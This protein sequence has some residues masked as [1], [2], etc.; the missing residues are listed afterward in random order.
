[1]AD[2]KRVAR[3][4]ARMR[5]D[6]LEEQVRANPLALLPVG[7]LEWHGRHLPVGL[8]AL[9]AREL[10][11]RISERTG[12][13]VLPPNHHSILGMHFP[14]TFRYRLGTLM[15]STYATLE[16]LYRY[17]FRVMI[18]MTGH[19]PPEQ[20]A[21]LMAA[22][23]LFMLTH[24]AAVVAGPEFM[25]AM[26]QGYIGD[27][28]AKWETSIMMELFPELVDESALSSFKGKRGWKLFREE[29]VQGENPADAA[30]QETGREI[31]ET[32]VDGFAELADELLAT[33]DKNT[34]RRFHREAADKF[35]RLQ[36][37]RAESYA[38]ELLLHGSV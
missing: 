27:H 17:G 34:A 25:V 35:F 37:R 11:L 15:N 2:G 38:R 4:F 13:V 5:P 9:K 8:D 3:E 24:D 7:T 29:G 18:V 33:R 31:V 21:L 6:E 10:C 23:E 36:F 26:D 14:W 16:Q 30:S 1:M 20:V 22:A 32:I 28:A 12:G 19:Y